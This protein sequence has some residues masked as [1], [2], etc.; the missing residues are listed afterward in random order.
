M[1]LDAFFGL[2]GEQSS[3]DDMLVVRAIRSI[4]KDEEVLFDYVDSTTSVWRYLASYG[5]VSKYLITS[6]D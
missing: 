3:K 4:F 5:F 1:E 2:K 6:P